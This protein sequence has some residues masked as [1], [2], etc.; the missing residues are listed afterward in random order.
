MADTQDFPWSPL[1]REVLDQVMAS[2]SLRKIDLELL[3]WLVWLSLLSVQELTRLVR[4][5]G[6]SF[7]PKTIAHHLLHLERLGLAASVVFSE[8]GWP[9]NLRRYYITDLGLYALVKHY[10][11]SIS[12]PKLVAC[13]PVSRTDL[14][15]RLARPVVHLALTEMVSRLIAESP[16][17]YNLSSY[18]QPWKQ[19]YGKIGAGGQQIWRC[20]AAFLLQTSTGAQH[21]FYVRVDQPECL[22]S[23]AEAKRFLSRLF[24]LRTYQ[25]LRGEVMPH[26]LLLSAPARFP[27]WAEQIERVTLLGNTSLPKGCIADN[28]KLSSGAYAPIWLPFGEMVSSGGRDLESGHVSLLSLLDQPATQDLVEQFSQYFTFQHLLICRTSRSLSRRT[29][30]LSRYV[31][32]SLQEEARHELQTPGGTDSTGVLTML[33]EELYG[34]KVT[35]LRIAALLNL[36]LT[37]QQK[38][39]LA[40]LVR[41]PHLSLLDLLGLLHPENQDERFIQHQLDPLLIELQLVRKDVWE[42]GVGWRERERYQIAETGLRFLAMRHGLTPAYY[43]IPEKKVRDEKKRVS[44][45]DPAVNWEQRGA[46]LLGR[47]M[48]HTNALYQCVR[49]IIE[50]G[51]RSG[52]YRIIGWKSARESVRCYY[53]PDERD[54]MNVRPDAELLYVQADGTRISSVLIEYDRGTTFYREYAAKFEAYSHYQ[55]CTRTMLPPILVVIQRSVTAQTIRTAIHEVG[56]DD[57]PVVLALENDLVHYGLQIRALVV[58]TDTCI[59]QHSL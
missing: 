8:V 52:A 30:W 36:T 24:A 41:H 40:L 43:L 38:A 39:I 16:P 47:Q 19:T 33:S 57:V 54:W 3:R 49:G 48:W 59:T 31:G 51:V 25:L 14:L 53:D 2:G 9:P 56:A 45:R 28:T 13:Y 12:V 21:A 27:F 17:G 42:A 20:D 26:L 29:K 34:D 7:D 55:R 11:A 18:Q 58:H 23:Q 6:S 37:G 4:V 5:D 10:P 15:A 46:A 44:P 32:D 1:S 35:R 22:F 50:V